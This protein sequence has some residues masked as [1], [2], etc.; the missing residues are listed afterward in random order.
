MEFDS[1]S[2][3]PPASFD[4]AYSC[5]GLP[6]QHRGGEDSFIEMLLTTN[7]SHSLQVR[8]V[9][10]LGNTVREQ[11]S[12]SPA[13]ANH[14][15]GRRSNPCGGASFGSLATAND[16]ELTVT[17]AGYDTNVSTAVTVD[18]ELT[19]RRRALIQSW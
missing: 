5:P 7:S 18:G 16:Y 11:K 4:V 9:D 19:G 10:D 2:I 3:E 8:V 15:L 14:M 1:Y 13:P 12:N 17:K 6:L